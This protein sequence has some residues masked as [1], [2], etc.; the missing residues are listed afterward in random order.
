MIEY[1]NSF[2]NKYDSFYNKIQIQKYNS[3]ILKQSKINEWTLD[4]GGGTGLLS[5]WLE[6]PLITLDISDK[7]LRVGKL[8][9]IEI[10]CIVGDMNRLPLRKNC[11]NQFLSFTALQNSSDPYIALNEICRTSENYGTHLISLLEKKYDETK[12][13]IWLSKSQVSYEISKLN[14]EDVLLTITVRK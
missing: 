9:N 10:Q 13:N 4:H 11:I 14:I 6:Y 3:S 5:K 2:S 1:Y 12:F 7:M 8:E